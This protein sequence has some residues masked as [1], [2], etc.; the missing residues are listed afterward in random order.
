MFALHKIICL[1]V[2]HSAYLLQFY[3]H[4]F[5][6][7]DGANVAYF[8]QNFEFGR[9]NYNQIKFLVDTLEAMNEKVLV[10]VPHKY[11]NRSYRSNAG[12]W[13]QRS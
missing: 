10:T 5:S 6:K 13:T 12:A 11:T 7:L 9:F 2:F 1:I 4:S 8:A 3:G